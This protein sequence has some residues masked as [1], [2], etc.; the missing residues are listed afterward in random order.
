MV[1][2]IKRFAVIALAVL[3]CT[4]L[5][6]SDK[7]WPQFRG[8]NGDG[9]APSTN[10][11]DSWPEGGPKEV[12]R[13]DS[14]PSYSELVVHNGKVYTTIGDKNGESEEE[15][16]AA[17]NATDGKELWRLT[18]DELFKNQFGDGTR[19]TPVID[20]DM[21]YVQTSGGKLIAATTAGKQVW[22]VDLV[23]KYQS[24]LPMFGYSSSP[25]IEGNQVILEA[26]GAENKY[27]ISFDK[28]TGKEIWSAL[29]GDAG[30][31]TAVRVDLEGTRQI[32]TVAGKDAVGMS[33]DG[34]E[35]WRFTY[36][37]Q[38]VIAMPLFVAPNQFMFSYSGVGYAKMISVSKDG[39]AWKPELKW[40][41]NRLKN[42]WSSS[43]ALGDLI[44][45]FDNATLK[46]LD[47]KTGDQ[48]WAK[49]GF[50][51]GALVVADN[52]LYILA[53]NGRLAMAKAS[54]DG[55][56][57]LG[58]VEAMKGKCWTAPTIADGRIYLRNQTE[59]VC[60]DLR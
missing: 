21:I 26:G 54:K 15:Y 39:D 12:W 13:A 59:M 55:Y 5:S 60:Y 50:G 46:C 4:G 25:F 40:E 8:H 3:L 14:G 57:E 24:K 28:K 53:D 56:E 17:F 36:A 22:S 6:A 37:D 30:Y 2:N 33:L 19:A 20:G 1:W 11:K 47:A 45:G 29:E 34:K 38:G 52:K 18:I 32:V 41:S 7:D 10:L 35:L 31:T 43:V 9:I 27:M 23:E 51:K 16:L 58:S 42:H 48:L 44:F 49:R